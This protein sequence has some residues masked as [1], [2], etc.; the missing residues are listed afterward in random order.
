MPF[1]DKR[2]KADRELLQSWKFLKFCFWVVLIG[3]PFWGLY[4]AVYWV[5]EFFGWID[6]GSLPRPYP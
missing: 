5:G 4:A 1:L 3:A 6:P 2:K